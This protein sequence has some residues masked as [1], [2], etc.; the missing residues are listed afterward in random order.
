MKTMRT[1]KVAQWLGNQGM[2]DAMNTL[3]TTF[4]GIEDL[5]YGGIEGFLYMYYGEFTPEVFLHMQC[6]VTTT[7]TFN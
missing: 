3:L 6:D 5:D 4:Q 1:Q 7:L 2:V